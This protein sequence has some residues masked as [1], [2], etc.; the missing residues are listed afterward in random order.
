MSQKVEETI[1]IEAEMDRFAAPLTDDEIANLVSQKT[2]KATQKSV[3]W[4]ASLFEEWRIQRNKKVIDG[5]TSELSTIPHKIEKLNHDEI[6]YCIARF[7]MEVRKCDT[8]EYPPKTL[9]YL[10]VMLQA[11]LRNNGRQVNLLNDPDFK[12]LQ[13]ALDASMRD[14]AKKGLGLKT[15]RVDIITFEQENIMWEKGILGDKDPQTLLDTMVYLIGMNFALRSGDEH[16]LLN[17]SQLSL[18]SRADGREYLEYTE[19]VSKSNQRGLAH[20]NVEQKTVKAFANTEKPKRCLIAFYKKYLE[21]SPELPD[22]AAFYLQPLKRLKD[23]QWF[24]GQPVGRNPLGN[25]I[26]KMCTAAG[27]EGW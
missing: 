20:Y 26:K 22:N 24:S 15:K 23:D 13:N 5:A 12:E 17:R 14:A 18:H 1:E 11:H 21:L 10:V 3:K 25:T 27:K 7:I 16:R 4:A 19:N 2:P 6:N 9:R 8:S